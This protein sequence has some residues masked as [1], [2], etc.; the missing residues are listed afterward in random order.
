MTHDLTAKDFYQTLN[1]FDDI[2]VAGKFG[3]KP[4]ALAQSG[5]ESAFAR[6]LIFVDKRRNHGLD[7]HAAYEAAM[8]A[9]N[10]E[11]NA[12]FAEDEDEPNAAD[13]VTEQGKDGSPS[14]VPLMTSRPSAS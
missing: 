11:I 2:A 7:D 3:A 9:T 6:S 13:P 1:G 10:A 5:D 12:Y 14:G 4:N 8:L